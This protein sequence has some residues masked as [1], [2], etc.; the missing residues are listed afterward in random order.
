[1]LTFAEAQVNYRSAVAASDLK[2]QGS[3]LVT[4]EIPVLVGHRTKTITLGTGDAGDV[5]PTD[6][7]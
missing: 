1:M 5:S 7:S 2:Q 3:H 6:F 4:M